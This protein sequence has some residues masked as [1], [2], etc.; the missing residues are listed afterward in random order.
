MNTS[1]WL[2]EATQR[3]NYLGSS[4]TARNKMPRRSSSQSHRLVE[5]FKEAEQ[6]KKPIPTPVETDPVDDQSTYVSRSEEE[7]EFCFETWSRQCW[8]TSLAIPRGSLRSQT[9]KRI[10]EKIDQYLQ[11]GD[12]PAALALRGQGRMNKCP[13]PAERRA[14][15]RRLYLRTLIG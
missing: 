14:Y 15:D 8:A 3:A 2:L 5:L 4:C 10:A 11:Q 6:G 13:S 12:L 1:W 7:P 9:G